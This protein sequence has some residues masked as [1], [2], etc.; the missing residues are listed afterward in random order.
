MPRRPSST[1]PRGKTDVIPA[2]SLS[3]L[4]DREL[5]R[6]LATVVAQERATTATLLAHIAEFDARRLYVGVGSKG[7]E[8]GKG[9]VT[10]RFAKNRAECP[11]EGESP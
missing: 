7:V 8:K 1:H 4:S 10:F 6:N 5:S 11:K 2:Y 9:D 3:H